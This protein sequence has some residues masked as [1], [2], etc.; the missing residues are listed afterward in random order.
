MANRIGEKPLISTGF[1]VEQERMYVVV[2]EN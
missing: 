1:I 2:E